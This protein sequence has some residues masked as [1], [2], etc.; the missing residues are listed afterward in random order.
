[1]KNY[2][3]IF[4]V[5]RQKIPSDHKIYHGSEVFD[6]PIP[7]K[8]KISG[9]FLLNTTLFCGKFHLISQHNQLDVN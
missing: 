3:N 9:H 2:L 7:R 5:I 1:M 4:K 8:N 6:F